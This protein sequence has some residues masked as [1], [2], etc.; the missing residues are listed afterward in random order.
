MDGE[1]R[2]TKRIDD[3]PSWLNGLRTH[4][5]LVFD[6]NEL[7]GCFRSRAELLLM[8]KTIDGVAAAA[9]SGDAGHGARWL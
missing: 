6:E 4:E 7:V 9:P 5:E 8:A 2:I 1:L 3:D